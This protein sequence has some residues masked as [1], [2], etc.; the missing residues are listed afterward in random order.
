M[1]QTQFRFVLRFDRVV[2]DLGEN[3]FVIEKFRI[4]LVRR[5]VSVTNDENFRRFVTRRLENEV[6]TF[7]FV[8][9]VER[10]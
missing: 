6:R 8:F 4:D 7:R 5:Q 10:T 3:V 9:F 2:F 1:F